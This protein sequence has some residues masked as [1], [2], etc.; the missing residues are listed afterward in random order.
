[1]SVKDYKEGMI[2]GA[3]PFEEKF[4]EIQNANIAALQKLGCKNS[5]SIGELIDIAEEHD[6]LLNYEWK[7]N[8]ELTSLAEKAI[9]LGFLKFCIRVIEGSDIPVDG[10][11]LFFN[12]L[13]KTFQIDPFQIKEIEI[14]KLKNNEDVSFQNLLYMTLCNYFYIANEN[15]KFEKK[16]D[17][18]IFQ[19]FR[20]SRNDRNEIHE[21]IEWTN[22]HLS[23]ESLFD[24]EKEQNTILEELENVVG[25]TSLDNLEDFTIQELLF[26]KSGD[27]QIICNKKLKFEAS[28]K[29]SG[30]VL[31][32]NCYIDY[33]ITD[34]EISVDKDGE[35][36]FE[37]CSFTNNSDIE[38]FFIKSEGK[39]SFSNCIFSN[40][41]AL[42][43]ATVTELVNSTV[44]YNEHFK[45]KKK[46][47]RENACI[48][49]FSGKL[50]I[51]DSNIIRAS[52]VKMF[53]TDY[54]EPF[55]CS[56]FEDI[57]NCENTVFKRCIKPA[58]SFANVV[59]SK[60]YNC[61]NILTVGYSS[62]KYSIQNSEF[63][64]CESILN[65][66]YR[67]VDYLIEN[68]KFYNCLNC[69]IEM[70]GS[71]LYIKGCEFR[72]LT[73]NISAASYFVI[74]NPRDNKLII[75]SSIFDNLDFSDFGYL[76]KLNAPMTEKDCCQLKVENCMFGSVKRKT[77]NPIIDAYCICVSQ[78]ISKLSL[79]KV[80]YSY[81]NTGIDDLLKRISIQNDDRKVNELESVIHSYLPKF[82]STYYFRDDIQNN[83]KARKKLEIL[84]TLIPNLD[85]E[86]I[87]GFVDFSITGNMNDHLVF[88]TEQCYFHYI[89]IIWSYYY[90]HPEVSSKFTII[91]D[92]GEERI[93][94]LNN[95]PAKNKDFDDCISKLEAI[96]HK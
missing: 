30:K 39:L 14:T 81:N 80:L 72:N 21:L 62:D 82:G 44:I 53:I 31:L 11:K 90:N 83:K 92:D 87:L 64:E 15:F 63:S 43:S 91:Y 5:N 26:V 42:T 84:K 40:C 58:K 32:K 78:F 94:L 60:F 47:S 67:S 34:N 77:S 66:S 95:S 48:H 51:K 25:C 8:Y 41:W 59:N 50:N 57:V 12:N 36:L 89:G 3:K 61:K 2:A 38:K 13:C 37:N 56:V 52:V 24:Y 96:L 49:L 28:I 55:D 23:L 54:P 16:Y 45:S 74:N 65:I 7:K 4:R 17:E 70:E 6:N 68:C 46:F 27:E 35:L 75:E 85:T 88:T 86:H 22:T 9:F 19:Y 76:I 29:V 10:Q 33:G 93:F 71:N 73:Q 79:K 69:I 20:V 18:E 1:M